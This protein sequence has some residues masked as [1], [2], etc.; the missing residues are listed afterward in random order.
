LALGL[1]SLTCPANVESEFLAAL[2]EGRWETVAALANQGV[3]VN[4]AT[5]SGRTALM[6]AAKEKQL[7]VIENLL[8]HGAEVNAT[9]PNGG[10]ALMYA[11]LGGDAAVT[12]ALLSSGAAVNLS[13]RN[14]WTALM[15]AVAKGRGEVAQ[16][17]LT[18]GADVNA[19]DI[20]QWTPLIRAAHQGRLGLV[21]LL[22]EQRAI[23]VNAQDDQGFTALHHAAAND[24]RHIAKSLIVH[25][26]DVDCRD[27]RGRTPQQVADLAGHVDL[28]TLLG[29]TLKP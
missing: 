9:N 11:A 20:Y 10:T 18:G 26:A 27:Q 6:L 12:R 14:G 13:S 7:K 19:P 5:D 29:G 2:K 8:A 25:G 15:V 24:Y 21:E 22:L 1:A 16:L 23:D 3:D 4:L 28:A 17:L